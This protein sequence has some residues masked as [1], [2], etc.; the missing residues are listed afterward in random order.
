[1]R[2]IRRGRT[3]VLPK[4]RRDILILVF[5]PYKAQ[6]T[7]KSEGYSMTIKKSKMRNS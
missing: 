5:I 1:M 6:E 3:R 2:E 4:K 7:L